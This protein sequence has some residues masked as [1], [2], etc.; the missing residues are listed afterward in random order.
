MTWFLPFVTP[1]PLVSAGLPDRLYTPAA[2]LRHTW[3]LVAPG[4]ALFVINVDDEEADCQAALFDE[5]GV[6]VTNLGLVT[7]AFDA[8][9]FE[10]RGWIARRPATAS[11]TS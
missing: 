10:L 5:V 3:S 6:E 9:D 4:G 2:V 7:S 11:T 8:L 1:R